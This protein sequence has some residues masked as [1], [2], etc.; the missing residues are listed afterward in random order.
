V[1]SGEARM[2]PDPQGCWTGPSTV[3]STGVLDRQLAGDL[4]GEELDRSVDRELAEGLHGE[5]LDGPWMSSSSGMTSTE[6]EQAKN[7][8]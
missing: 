4:H 2:G 8:C 7:A 1:R 6:D 3:S 5:E